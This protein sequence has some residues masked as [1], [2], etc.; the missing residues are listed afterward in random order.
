G[1]Q[2]ICVPLI[3]IPRPGWRYWLTLG[4]SQRFLLA[5][6]DHIVSIDN[7][8]LCR[9]EPLPQLLLTMEE[10]LTMLQFKA[11]LMY[12]GPG[13]STAHDALSA[14]IDEVSS[15]F[16]EFMWFLG[17]IVELSGWSRYRA[18]LDAEKGTTGHYSLYTNHSD[19]EIMFHVAP[20]LPF[21]PIDFQRI[22]RKRHI[23]ND[24][25]VIVY[26]DSELPYDI[27][28]ITSKQNHIICIVKPEQNQYRVEFLARESVP[29]FGPLWS[30]PFHLSQN[31]QSR[32]LFLE[33]CISGIKAAYTAPAFSDK[34]QKT[35]LA[36]LQGIH[37]QCLPNSLSA[38]SRF[39]TSLF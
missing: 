20:L 2:H 14:T 37:Q 18:G 28:T 16:L 30:A 9:T 11:G 6:I 12:L 27:S 10:K 24:I 32:E 36:M 21:N 23:G 34:I 39:A 29:S 33:K 5:P 7:L 17:D 31:N 35:R 38:R 19:Y 22:E 26:H 1:Y 25:L 13:K 8:L 15:G 3:D 4:R